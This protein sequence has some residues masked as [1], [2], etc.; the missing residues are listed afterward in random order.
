MNPSSEFIIER[1]YILKETWTIKLLILALC[2]TAAAARAQSADQTAAPQFVSLWNSR[3]IANLENENLI[4]ELCPSS[5]EAA[6]MADCRQEKLKAESWNLELYDKPEDMSDKI[7]TLTVT[8]TPGQGLSYE[9]VPAGSRDSVPFVPDLFDIDWGYGPHSEHTVLKRDGDWA[10]LPANPFPRPVWLTLR[11]GFETALRVYDPLKIGQIYTVDDRSVTV[12]EIREDGLLL[13]DEIPDDM[14]CGEEPAA[15][16]VE[17]ETTLWP[18][19]GLF[20]EDGHFKLRMKYT[21]GC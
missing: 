3:I 7:G 20:D 18:W 12:Q 5:L 14:P 15:D 10:L 6:Q 2:M 9:F 1:T 19:A 21:R 4:G 11:A 13:R 17:P 16:A 8:A